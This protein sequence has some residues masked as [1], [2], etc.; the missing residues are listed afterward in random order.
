MK[1]IMVD[2]ETLSTIP[3]GTILQIG[4]VEFVPETGEIISEFLVNINR[5]DSICWGFTTSVETVQWWEK[6]SKEAKDSLNNPK[7]VSVCEALTQFNQFVKDSTIWCHANFDLPFICVALAK[8]DTK[9]SWYFKNYVDLRTL[10]RF[11]NYDVKK[12]IRNED[13]IYHSA[14]GDC[15]FQIECVQEAITKGKING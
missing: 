7:P 12:C 14:I 4:A 6:Q 1:N 8:I 13:N 3:G 11:H 5:E 10:F 2:I 15:K 9:P